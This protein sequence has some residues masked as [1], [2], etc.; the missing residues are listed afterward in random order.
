VE[1]VEAEPTHLTAHMQGLCRHADPS[2]PPRRA[3]A[4]VSFTETQRA[5]LKRGRQELRLLGHP[6]AHGLGSLRHTQQR[7]TL[8][9]R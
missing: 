3:C 1:A 9:S 8:A 6:E 4:R 5:W 7:V 2:T